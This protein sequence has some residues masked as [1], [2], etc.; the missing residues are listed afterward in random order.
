MPHDSPAPPPDK[1]H[2]REFDA[3]AWIGEPDTRTYQEFQDA[4]G[5]LV[6]AL[7]LA[8]GAGVALLAIVALVTQ[9]TLRVLL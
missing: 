5:K 9:L 3:E 2:V 1:P 4:R 7:I 6:F 8:I